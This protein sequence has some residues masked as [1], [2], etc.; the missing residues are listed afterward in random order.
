MCV[1]PRLRERE[2]GERADG[3]RARHP[4]LALEQ[5]PL[6]KVLTVRE[7]IDLRIGAVDGTVDA[8]LARLDDVQLIALVA[9][10][11]E[12]LAVGKLLLVELEQ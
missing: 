8:H 2:A 6:A 5:R 11:K 10:P 4:W 12:E 3:L 7:Q 9:L 1:Q